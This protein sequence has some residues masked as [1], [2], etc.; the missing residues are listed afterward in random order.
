[1]N[2]GAP[3]LLMVLVL[4]AFAALFITP[5]IVGLYRAARASEWGPVMGIVAA[6]LVGFGWLIGLC[7]LLGP[8]RRARAAGP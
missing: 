8:D 2:L 6:W 5:T 7:Y 3:E 4:M 1:M